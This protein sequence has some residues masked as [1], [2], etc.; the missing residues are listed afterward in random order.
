MTQITWK[1]VTMPDLYA[2]ST[3]NDYGK[4]NFEQQV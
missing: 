3:K 1:N 2:Q 4:T